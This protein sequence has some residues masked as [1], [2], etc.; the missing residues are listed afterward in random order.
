MCRELGTAKE[1]DAPTILS[2]IKDEV[3]NIAKSR[4]D[5]STPKP[6]V[7]DKV[8]AEDGYAGEA[9]STTEVSRTCR[10]TSAA[11]VP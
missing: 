8:W 9:S 11:S 3:T 5:M 4:R 7:V 6:M 1:S 2:K 10:R